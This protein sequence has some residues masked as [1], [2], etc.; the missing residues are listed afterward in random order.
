MN[1]SLGARLC[2]GRRVGIEWR[3]RRTARGTVVHAVLSHE[4]ELSADD[5]DRCL[6]EIGDGERIIIESQRRVR[7]KGARA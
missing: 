4:G 3:R 2:D 1:I 6:S 7:V 5:L